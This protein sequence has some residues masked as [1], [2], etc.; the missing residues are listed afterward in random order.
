[1]VYSALIAQRNGQLSG[2][3]FTFP[4]QKTT[5]DEGGQQVLSSTAGHRPMV[6]AVLLQTV[7][8][9]DV[10]GGDPALTV[11]RPYFTPLSILVVAQ[12][13]QLLTWKH[14]VE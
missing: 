11:F 2:A 3:A 1:M 4:D 7:Y 12:H 9:C 5:I 10:V 14:K 6:P 13:T 8:W